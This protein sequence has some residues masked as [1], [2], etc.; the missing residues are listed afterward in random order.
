MTWRKS[1]QEV[2]TGCLEEMVQAREAKGQEQGEACAAA[3]WE[4]V[5]TVWAGWAELAPAQGQVGS[6]YVH[7]AALQWLIGSASLA[8]RQRV[9][10][11][12]LRW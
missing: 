7:H 4:L 6:V 1:K 8:I 12:E 9:R 10:A 5:V 3:A 2:N 11:V